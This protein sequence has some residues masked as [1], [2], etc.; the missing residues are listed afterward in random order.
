VALVYGD[1]PPNPAAR[2]DGGS[3]FLRH[4]AEGLV[5]RGHDVTAIV[6]SRDDRPRPYTSPAGV[7]VEPLIQ[8]WRLRAAFG[9]ELKALRKVVR[10]N[11]VDI[12][13][14]IY[15]DPF[16]R[17]G[18]DTYHLPFLLKSGTGKPLLV[19][20]FGFGVTGSS[21]VDRV[22]LFSLFVAA[23]RVVITDADL[24]TRFKRSLPWWAAK[25]R[26]G[27]VGSI[28]EEGSPAWS[29]DA[30]GERKLAVGLRPAQRYIGFFGFWSPD[31]GLEDLFEAV[32]RL[33]R[34]GQGVS[35][36]L[37]G[38]RA[39]EVRLEHERRLLGL[40][41]K[42]GIADAVIDTGALS[43]EDVVRYMVA[44]DVCALPFKVNP[45]GRS[46]LALA[47]ELGMPTVVTRP[48]G[49]GAAL[50]NGLSLLD[51]TDPDHI[52]AAIARLLDDPAAQR[53][54]AGAAVQ[55]ARHWS[56]DAIVN[57]YEILYAEIDRRQ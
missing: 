28:A 35:L 42:L 17:Y 9:G 43:S 27:L 50:L 41:T 51:A 40:A 13:H 39:P 53:A 56:W 46:S 7:R 36:V 37:I 5:E 4:L 33:R 47:L 34:A 3:D 14:L 26:G 15:P 52:A 49:D 54:T 38:G 55:A 18:S 44:M 48:Y 31:K 30:L 21:L 45:L 25:A 10:D 20:F 6:S 23:D 22:G 32:L 24:L 12:V 1:Y 57:E 2:I 19:T 29:N 8:D 16:L 11:R